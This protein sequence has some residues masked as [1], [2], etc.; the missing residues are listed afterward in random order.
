[1]SSNREGEF[2][3]ANQHE[4]VSPVCARTTMVYA[5]KVRD[6]RLVRGKFL[7]FL[8]IFTLTFFSSC[9]KLGYGVLLWST[10]EPAILSGTILPV[11]IKSNINQTWVVGIPKQY[12]EDKKDDNK[13]EIPLS[14]L[15]FAGSKRKARRFSE[16]FAYYAPVYAENLQDRLPIRDNPDN[17]A[18]SVYRL[19]TGEIIKI[20]DKV[21]GNP[22]ISMTG[23]PLPGDWYKV[24]THNGVTGFCFSYRLKIFNHYEGPVQA[25]H[26]NKIETAPDPDLDLVLS[27][28]WSPESY[29]QMINTRRID[30]NELK[31]DYR[32]DPGQ[33]TGIAKI[34]LPGMEMEFVYEGIIPDGERAWIFEGTSLQ[35][36]LRTNTSLAVQ[37]MESTGL[38][39]TL[40]FVALSADIDDLILQENTRRES[41]YALIFNQGPVFTSNNYGTITFTQT[42]GFSWT[43]FDLLV[44]QVI[45]RDVKGEGQVDMGLF[46][47][48]SFEERYNGA[49]TLRFTDGSKLILRFMYNLDNQ[50][51]RLEVLPDYAVEDITVTRRAPSPM[52]M[53]FFRDSSL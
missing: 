10:E 16:E 28:K 35:M 5:A 7:F 42:G 34:I 46:I 4:R 47:T 17:G 38:R 23:A 8:F 25:V 22:P 15:N 39:R 27:K 12:R 11:Y 26:G 43:G 52:V 31:K 21:E 32:F 14:Q 24:L 1:M 6:V 48:Q 37:F 50:G 41:Q 36:N 2:S 45:P 53:Y 13:I 20:L 30:I 40:L 33:D 29:L 44:P 18:R 3:A 51:L 9:S 19:R 49:F